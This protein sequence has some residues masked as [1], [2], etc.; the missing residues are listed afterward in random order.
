MAG[1][2]VSG[3]AK[4][5]GSPAR[6]RGASNGSVSVRSVTWSSRKTLL[7]WP[8]CRFRVRVLSSQMFPPSDS[9]PPVPAASMFRP[10]KS[11]KIERAGRMR[12]PKST[13]S[14]A[15]AR[16]VASVFWMK[17]QWVR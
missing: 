9:Q 1:L 5:V 13:L 12:V 11:R 3:S 16:S 17:V 10:E 14:A 8:C 7:L 2:P 6:F 4:G 15:L